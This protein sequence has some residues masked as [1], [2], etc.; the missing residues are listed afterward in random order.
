VPRAIDITSGPM[1][2]CNCTVRRRHSM[3]FQT[4]ANAG[5]PADASRS[6]DVATRGGATAPPDRRARIASS[7]RARSIDASSAASS[8]AASV[9]RT[10]Q[11]CATSIAA[12]GASSRPHSATDR[13][14]VGATT[15]WN[16]YSPQIAGA[17]A[18]VRPSAVKKDPAS[19]AS[20]R[21]RRPSMRPAIK[22]IAINANMKIDQRCRLAP[23]PP[24]SRHD[25][26]TS[27]APSRWR[28]SVENNTQR[29]I[30]RS[31]DGRIVPPRRSTNTQIRELINTA[32]CARNSL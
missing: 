1:K 10:H 27:A 2:T 14:K 4:M 19:G 6:V 17:D 30:A 28:F 18:S 20:I 29:L 16:G 5:C 32:I 11:A 31:G 22:A 13:A 7:R 15:R 12:A 26:R 9:R 23:I 25:E 21:A 24:C 3:F 8:K